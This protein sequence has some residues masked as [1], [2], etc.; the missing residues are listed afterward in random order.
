MGENQRVGR[1]IVIVDDNAGFR[2]S[3]RRVLEDQ[4]YRVLAEAADGSSGLR[5]A[6]DADPEVALIDVQLPD[7]DGFEVARRLREARAP[8]AVVL[9]SSRDAVDFGPLIAASGA[10]GFVPKG[11]LSAGALES[12]LG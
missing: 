12:L 10:R 6:L 3:A 1:T 11:G 9:T 4:G 5:A 2:A 8:A 7:I